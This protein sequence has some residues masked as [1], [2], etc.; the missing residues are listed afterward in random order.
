MH[1]YICEYKVLNNHYPSHPKKEFD[2]QIGY[3]CEQCKM[4]FGAS[5]GDMEL[6]KLLV[7]LQN[8]DI[9]AD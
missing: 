7:H 2:V 9:N 8:G 3:E 6:H 5:L 1:I 4:K